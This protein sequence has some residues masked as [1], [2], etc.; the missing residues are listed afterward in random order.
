VGTSVGLSLIST[1]GNVN[2]LAVGLPEVLASELK[3]EGEFDDAIL[4]ANEEGPLVIP[5][6]I[7]EEL[8]RDDGNESVAS[9]G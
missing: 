1:V 2:G 9:S 7:G 8:G 3:K 4:G 6:S 5:G